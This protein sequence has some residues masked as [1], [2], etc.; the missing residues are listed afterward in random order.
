MKRIETDYNCGFSKQFFKVR[1]CCLQRLI[2]AFDILGRYLIVLYKAVNLSF[3][4]ENPGY[5]VEVS[6]K[7]CRQEQP[8]SPMNY[9]AYF[10]REY[11][12]FAKNPNL[13]TDEQQQQN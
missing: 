13:R 1:F 6:I 9:L 10:H 2:F 8:D 12:I 4:G 3:S 5:N 7:R 11:Y